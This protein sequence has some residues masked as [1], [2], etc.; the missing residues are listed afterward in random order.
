MSK[1]LNILAAY[2]T[3]AVSS[4]AVSTALSFAIS[5]VSISKIFSAQ[6]DTEHLERIRKASDAVIGEM[7]YRLTNPVDYIDCVRRCDG[8]KSESS[9]RLK[10]SQLEFIIG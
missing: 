1:N 3:I 8:K 6:S 7:E 5:G 9:P 4:L 2:S 10:G